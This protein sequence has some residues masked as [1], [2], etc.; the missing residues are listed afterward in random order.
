[1]FENEIALVT[2]ASRGIGSAIADALGQRGATVIGTAT[3]ESGASAISDRFASAGVRGRGMLL[4]VT[5][6]SSVAQL[7]KAV[8]EDFGAP[9]ILVNNA[10]IPDAQRAVVDD[11]VSMTRDYFGIEGS[12]EK[13]A[14]AGLTGAAAAGG[15][16]ETR[17][18]LGGAHYDLACACA[19]ASGGIAV[20]KAKPKPVA[21]EERERLGKRAVSN[22]ARAFELGWDNLVHLRKDRDLDALRR[23]ADFKA[24]V[25]EWEKK[26][27]R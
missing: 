21:P 14:A 23:R 5:E 1:M 3:S 15:D 9:S 6:P 19:L 18:H 4:N 26:W 10:G 20:W 11:V 24:L 27:S 22:L 12:A 17:R 8:T 7:L 13:L 2:G 16:E 25:A